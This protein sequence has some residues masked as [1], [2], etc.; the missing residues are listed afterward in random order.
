MKNKIQKVDKFNLFPE[1]LEKL[2]KSELLLVKGGAICGTD[3]NLN[4][5]T[6][7]CN[8]WC[9]TNKCSSSN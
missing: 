3:I 2:E 9:P 5:G 1:M 4:C 6:A 7:N 8:N